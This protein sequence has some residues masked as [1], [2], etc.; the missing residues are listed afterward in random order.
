[1]DTPR[2]PRPDIDRMGRMI[3][4]DGET[5]ESST[6]P[7]KKVLMGFGVI[8]GLGLVAL[9]V[10]GLVL[11]RAAEDWL[12]N[13]EADLP[14]LAEE[15]VRF[16]SEH[17]QSACIDE[18]LKRALPCAALEMTCLMGAGLFGQSCLDAATPDPTV[19]IGVP[20]QTAGLELGEWAQQQCTERGHQGN[21]ACVAFL[22]QAV[23]SYCATQRAE[24]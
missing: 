10:V 17:D 20:A 9:M 3:I 15:G 24:E 16:A 18:G 22:T 5:M 1:M 12:V 6:F 7:W 14:A 13:L 11:K 8:S 23:G 4:G 2:V 19:C 21:T